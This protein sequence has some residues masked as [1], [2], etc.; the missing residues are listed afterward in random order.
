VQHSRRKRPRANFQYTR[1]TATFQSIYLLWLNHWT[2]ITNR[3]ILLDAIEHK[4]MELL[5]V[6]THSSNTMKI[7][8]AIVVT[9]LPG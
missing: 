1:W 9:W 4:I 8:C 6:N 2:Q 5:L 3:S 7:Y